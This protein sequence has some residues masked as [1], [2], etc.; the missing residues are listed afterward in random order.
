MKLNEQK[1]YEDWSSLLRESTNIKDESKLRWLSVYAHNHQVFESYDNSQLNESYMAASFSNITGQGNVVMPNTHATAS[2]FYNNSLKGSGDNFPTLLP[3]AIQ[4]AART[5]GFDIVNVVPMQGPTGVLA[6]VDHEYAGG[7]LDSEDNPYMIIIGTGLIN[8][9]AYVVGTTY[10]G[11]SAATDLN[12][13][14]L[15]NGAYVSDGANLLKMKYVGKSRMNGK[16]IFRILGSYVAD[17][18]GE[19]GS[20]VVT[21]AADDTVSVADVFDGASLI[22]ADDTNKPK[23]IIQTGGVPSAVIVTQT[24]E[25]V[26]SLED[27]I[28]QF[29]GA[30]AYDTDDWTANFADGTKNVSPMNRGVGETT[31]FRAMGMKTYTKSIEAKSYQSSVAVT[32]E[33]I[34]DLNR[35]FGMDVM[36]MVES[37]L[38]NEISQSI[39]AHILDRAFKLG[40]TNHYNM[41]N[42]EGLSLNLNLTYSGS[43]SGSKTYK[44]STETDVAIPYAAFVNMGT[45]ENLSTIQRR[46]KSRCLAASAVI[47]QRGRRGPANFIVTN[48]QIGTAIQDNAQYTFAPMENTISQSAGGLYPLGTVAG[49]TIYIDPRMGLTDN[50]VLVGRKGNEGEGEPGLVFMPY[51]MAEMITTIAE[52]TMAPKTAIK[53]RYALVEAGHFPESQYLVFDVITAANSPLF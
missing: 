33:Q 39:N 50:R 53:T 26:R 11:V 9:T 24:A 2:N 34:Q 3:L 38:I 7:R 19:A 28:P 32:T 5:V 27:H 10:W 37:N 30:G 45:M 18:T 31:Y 46:I 41:Y 20:E 12:S 1:I 22:V 43:S 25:L 8:A 29:A 52:G 13:G 51:I 17:V 49:M 40:W 6:Y 21:V 16:A 14:A 48:L 47:Y 35:Q 36:G 23:C 42:V 44:D 15:A 4:V